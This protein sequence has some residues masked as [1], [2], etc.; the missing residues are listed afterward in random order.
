MTQEEFHKDW[1]VLNHEEF[2]K[3]LV[4][5]GEE[6]YIWYKKQLELVFKDKEIW[7]LNDEFTIWY[8]E[9]LRD[10]KNMTEHILKI[11]R[12]ELEIE[13]GTCRI[14]KSKIYNRPYRK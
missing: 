13:R 4:K 10:N 2:L 7:P 14:Q 1:E 11:N 12:Y 5:F 6:R 9:L 3:H 8:K